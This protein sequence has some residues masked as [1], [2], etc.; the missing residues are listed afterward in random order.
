MYLP[1]FPFPHA[2]VRV[3][4]AFEFYAYR[5]IFVSMLESWLRLLLVLY[6]FGF[7]SYFSGALAVMAIPLWFK[8]REPL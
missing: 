5:Y 1:E 3:V 2:E 7:L 6:V 4:A 8:K